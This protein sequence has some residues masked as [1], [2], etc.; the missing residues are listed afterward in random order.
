MGPMRIFVSYRREDSAGWAGRLVNDLAERFGAAN[1]F[2]DIHSI[3]PGMDF[4]DAINDMLQKSDCAL[5]VIGPAW[6]SL[7]DEA[8]K[9][10]LDDTSDYVR[11]EV[12]TALQRCSP[13]IPVLVGGAMMPAPALLPDDIKA[14]AR[15]NA[16]ELTDLR[17][18]YDVGQLA[19]W[20]AASDRPDDGARGP[21]TSVDIEQPPWPLN[22]RPVFIPPLPAGAHW[23]A[24]VLVTA[25]LVFIWI[26]AGRSDWLLLSG[27]LTL[28][29]GLGLTHAL[30]AHF[31]RMLRRLV[32]RDVL[33]ASRDEVQQIC[34]EMERDVARRWAYRLGCG[35][36]LSIAL[37]F[38]VAFP[39][40]QILS[41]L[42]LLLF[43]VIAGYFVGCYF[44]RLGCYGTI[45]HQLQKRN[46]TFEVFPGHADK[47]GGL[48][49]VG[50]FCL[51][52]GMIA[53]MPAL[54]LGTWLILF[55]LPYFARNYAHWQK[56]YTALL[57]VAISAEIFSFF[58]PMLFFHREMQGSKQEKFP[59]ADKLSKEI[60]NLQ[61]TDPRRDNAMARFEAIERLPTWPIAPRTRQTFLFVLVIST[62]P[63][64]A[65]VLSLMGAFAN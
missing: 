12:A 8:G 56:P 61:I 6:L 55:S 18:P 53:A 62:L 7:K 22:D 14:L 15:R 59:E 26:D 45:G 65:G 1:V 37:A 4:L 43:E 30:P 13:V 44:A 35:M 49:P 64:I 17:W 5:V 29:A 51:H 10:R 58:Y 57:I 46:L 38:F 2:Q 36:A 47:A 63:L 31:E 42:P 48:K 11:L 9:R 24:A 60:N 39:G 28:F 25:A 54:F 52:Q 34:V 21:E 40:P 16:A 3:R 19:Q 50:D 33:N 32:E 23:F 20:I 41:R 27:S